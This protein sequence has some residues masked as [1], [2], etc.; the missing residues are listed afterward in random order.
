MVLGVRAGLQ[1]RQNLAEIALR[2]GR[3]ANG[4]LCAKTSRYLT[5]ISI[6]IAVSKGFFRYLVTR[7]NSCAAQGLCT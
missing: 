3:K 5:H 6:L 2:L 4:A 1:I 7:S